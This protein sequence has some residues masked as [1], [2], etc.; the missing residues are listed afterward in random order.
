M[1]HTPVD[2]NLANPENYPGLNPLLRFKYTFSHNFNTI[3]EG[4]LKKYNW[5]PRTSIATVAGIKQIDEDRIV[6]Y[7][8]H[9]SVHFFGTT[10]EQVTINRS[11]KEVESRIIT[12]NH[13][14]LTISTIEKTSIKA[15]SEENKS[16]V[17]TDVFDTQGNGS[18][19][20]EI[21][22]HQCSLLLK[23]IKFN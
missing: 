22:K 4:F 13:D 14:N 1:S 16:N 2:R 18:A 21:F 5:E 10:W 11:T 7:R 6:F 8:R 9:E 19:K 15:S 23:A 3:A 20:V 12:P 17:E